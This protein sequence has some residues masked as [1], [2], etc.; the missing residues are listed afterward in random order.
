MN[1][2]QFTPR[3]RDWD[4]GYWAGLLEGQKVKKA[5]EARIEQLEAENA[6]M[7]PVFDAAKRWVMSNETRQTTYGLVDAVAGS[8][9]KRNAGRN[10]I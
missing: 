4:N 2:E 3:E 9:T 10:R 6:R 1:T 8:E 5:L 7:K